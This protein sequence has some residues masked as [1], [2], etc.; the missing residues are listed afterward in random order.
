MALFEDWQYLGSGGYSEVYS[1][2]DRAVNERRAVKLLDPTAITDANGFKSEA[3]TLM[4]LEHPRIVR[5][6]DAGF[7]PTDGIEP[8]CGKFYVSTE[9]MEGGSVD[10]LISDGPISLRNAIRICAEICEAVQYA[11]DKLCIHRDIKP[12]NIFLESRGQAS[13]SKLGDFGLA[14]YGRSIP[15]AEGYLSHVAPEILETGIATAKSDV[16]ALGVALYKMLNGAP[17]S[18]WTGLPALLARNIASGKYPAR[19][20]FQ[21]YVPRPIRTIVSRALHIDPEK[22]YQSPDQLRHA[23]ERV[24]IRCDWSIRKDGLGAHL[25]GTSSIG[26]I[27]IART[28]QIG[29]KATFEIYKIVTAPGK[30]RRLA[31]DGFADK[32]PRLTQRHAATVLQRIASTGS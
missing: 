19:D 15:T 25:F 23:L 2:F 32:D 18:D 24:P 20:K 10:G 29:D 27:F 5:V 12:A 1:A 6:F 9:L 3:Q 28:A 4:Q 30:P 17:M 26:G 31:K 11:H 13:P 14:Q 16:Y 8:Y 7:G 22:R 21:A